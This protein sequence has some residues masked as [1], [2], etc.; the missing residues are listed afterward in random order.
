[1]RRIISILMA[2][3]LFSA[4]DDFV[5]YK[6]HY[7][8]LQSIATHSLLG[9][10]GF[11][12]DE[13]LILE[14]DEWGRTLFAFVGSSIYTDDY[15]LAVLI[16]QKT[17]E[18]NAYFYD[19]YNFIVKEC[20]DYVKY[21]DITTDLVQQYFTDEEIQQLE[22]T[23]DWGHPIQNELLFEIKIARK[24]VDKISVQK[25]RAAFDRITDQYHY[26]NCVPLST[27]RNGLTLYLLSERDYN[28]DEKVY[29][30]GNSYM[31]M[32]DKTGH[33]VS[34]TSLETLNDLW[35]YQEQLR[36]F[37]TKN[38]WVFHD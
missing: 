14:K 35:M 17:T 15:I 1:M 2:L 27:D 31:A 6:G 25:Q 26:N 24:K 33:L 34:E 7:P 37:K 4:C 11:E 36:A 10:F 38:G 5:L 3:F 13:I 29:E 8:E 12:S 16:S 22:A 9:V 23:N 20:P 28:S 21:H 19:T 18:T 30:F 32:F